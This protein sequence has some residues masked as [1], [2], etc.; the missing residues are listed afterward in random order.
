[1][2]SFKM[3]SFSFGGK[4]KVKKPKI[5]GSL[6]GS[7]SGSGPDIKVKGPKVKAPKGDVD[8]DLSLGG[9]ADIDV[10]GPKVDVDLP[11]ADVDLKVGG[12]VDIKGPKVKADIDVPKADIDV[13]ADI[14]A[15]GPDFSMP[16][17]KMPSFS[18]GGKAKVKKP[19]IDGSLSGS[20]SGSGPDIKV[21]GPKVKAPKGDVDVDLS[22]G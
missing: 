6:N 22:L 19:K 14:D 7:L 18:F 2:P 17:F 1:M 20:L 13:D 4:A 3:P 16:S 15:K 21:K 10:K 11:K 9:G 5:D 8:V 12:D